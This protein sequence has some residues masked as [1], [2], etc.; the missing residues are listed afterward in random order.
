LFVSHNMLAVQS[1]CSRAIWL[2]GGKV[3]E[4]GQTGQVIASYSQTSFSALTEQVW[5][6]RSTAPGNDQVRLHRVCVRPEDGS[7]VDTIVM[8]TPLALEIEF[9]N[10]IPEARLHITLHVYTEQQ[11]VA[12]TTGSAQTDPEWRGRAFPVGLFR[13]VCH[14]PGKLLNSGT[15][16]VMLLV[17]KNSDTL[18]YRLEDALAFD[19]HDFDERSG[20]WF[21]KEPGVVQPMLEWKTDYLGAT[22]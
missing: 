1:L 22:Q 13:S 21:G 9:W 10:L 11:L 6:D 5:D 17:V 12:F 15:H 2:H 18:I 14:I 20:H 16:R 19:V 8:Q 3:V 7:R 4:T